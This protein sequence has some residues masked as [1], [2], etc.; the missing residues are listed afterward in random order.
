MLNHPGRPFTEFQVAGAVSEAFG[1]AASV[2]IAVSGFNSCGLWPVNEDRWEEHE[3]A[4][5]ETTDRPAGEY[6][7]W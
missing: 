1:R 4:A 6:K 2:R 3:F 7:Y 5:A